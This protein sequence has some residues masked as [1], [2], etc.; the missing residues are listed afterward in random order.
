MSNEISFMYRVT[1]RE[2]EIHEKITEF[3]VIIQKRVEPK[4]FHK[5]IFMLVHCVKNGKSLKLPKPY[6]FVCQPR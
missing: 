2:N 1:A 3:I 4:G 5:I 6:T